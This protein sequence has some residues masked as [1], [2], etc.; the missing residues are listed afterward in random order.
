[1]CTV[2]YSVVT[3]MLT[4]AHSFSPGSELDFSYCDMSAM[5]ISLS[6]CTDSV[7]FIL[8]S[9][10]SCVVPFSVR[11][12][13]HTPVVMVCAESAGVQKS[14]VLCLVSCLLVVVLVCSCD[15]IH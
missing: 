13:H 2:S 1:M 6:L 11:P 12:G 8:F 14:L 3:L 10:V 4:G 9:F 7:M 5:T 15:V